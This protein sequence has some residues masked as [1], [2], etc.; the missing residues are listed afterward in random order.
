MYGK[1]SPIDPDLLTED[2]NAEV[3]ALRKAV[4]EQALTVLLQDDG[5]KPLKPATKTAPLYYIQVGGKPGNAIS[6]LLKNNLKAT[7]FYLPLNAGEHTADSVSRL[8]EKNKAQVIVGLH[9]VGR[10]PAGNFGLSKATADFIDAAGHLTGRTLLVF[11]NPYVI[12][13]FEGSS[14]NNLVACYEDDAIFQ[15]VGYNWLVGKIDASG[16]LPV[17]VGR[18]VYGSGITKK[19][20]TPS[21]N[22]TIGA[23]KS[24]TFLA[25]DSIAMEAI[26]K[27][28]I[29]GCVVAVLHKGKLLFEKA[30]GYTTYDSSRAVSINTIYDLASVTKISATTVS[31]M[32]LYEQGKIDL[33]A[34]ISTYLPW[35]TGTD[36][37][38]LLVENLLLHQAGLNAYIPFFKEVTDSSG[39][40][41]PAIF[42]HKKSAAFDIT[43]TDDLY[44][45]NDW[46]DTMYSRI[47]TSK[48]SEKEMKYVY[49]DNDFILLGKIVEAASGLPLDEFARENFYAPMGMYTTGFKPNNTFELTKI[50]PTEKEKN[51]RQQQLWGTTHDP[52]AAMFGNVA[53]HAGLFSN[54]PDLMKLYKMLL[55][56]GKYEGKQYLKKTT[57]DFFTAYNTPISRRGLGFDKTEKDNALRPIEKAYPSAS[58]SAQTYGHTGYTGTCVWVDPARQLVYIFLSNRVYPDGGDNLKLSTLNIRSRIQEAIYAALK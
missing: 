32:K 2:L 58:A 20:L 56:G 34:P 1:T 50:A 55:E 33:K 5:W 7:I 38:N 47:A 51:F 11:G 28:A 13:N 29:P 40:V 8:M 26:S 45:R 18:F 30:Y 35:L 57:I 31:V 17:T 39:K 46:V 14:Y 21:N 16:T 4:A 22:G 23:N 44:M 54:A 49:S 9:G 52:G 12:K 37:A 25:I 43:V 3:P 24:A 41:K 15:E 6:T 10:N 36:K 48:L 19:K 53:G 42:Q 27:K